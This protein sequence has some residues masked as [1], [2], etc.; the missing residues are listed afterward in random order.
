MEVGVT[1]LRLAELGAS[2]PHPILPPQGG[3]E[4]CVPDVWLLSAPRQQGGAF[5]GS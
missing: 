3:K 4:A 5:F 2:T 1:A